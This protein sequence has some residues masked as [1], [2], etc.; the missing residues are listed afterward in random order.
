M[1]FPFVLMLHLGLEDFTSILPRQSVAQAAFKSLITRKDRNSH[2]SGHQKRDSFGSKSHWRY[3]Q[4]RYA[5]IMP[6]SF[7]LS[8]R[9]V[10]SWPYPQG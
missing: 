4:E 9:I 3:H 1:N 5:I 2:R 7:I 10:L 8:T 6:F